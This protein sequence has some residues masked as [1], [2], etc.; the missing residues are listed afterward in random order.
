LFILQFVVTGLATG[1]LGPDGKDRGAEYPLP[2]LGEEEEEEVK[3]EGKG[4]ALIIYTTFIK[5]NKF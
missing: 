3:G 2:I 5:I 4:R 1:A